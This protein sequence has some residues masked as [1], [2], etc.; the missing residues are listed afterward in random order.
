[1]SQRSK[2]HDRGLT[3]SVSGDEAVDYDAAGAGHEDRK[4]P[5][6]GVDAVSYFLIVFWDLDVA[7]RGE[8]TTMKLSQK[9]AEQFGYNVVSALFTSVSTHS[10]FS[11][12]KNGFDFQV[13]AT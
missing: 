5:Q 12:L 2:G 3:K 13:I 10:L 9:A 11:S 7:K 4:H 1:M 6:P 8:F